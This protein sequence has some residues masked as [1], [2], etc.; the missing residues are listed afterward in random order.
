MFVGLLKWG[1]IGSALIVF[2]VVMLIA[3]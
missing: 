3:S 1:T 2:I